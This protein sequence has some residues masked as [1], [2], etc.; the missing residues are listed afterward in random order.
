M[1]MMCNINVSP[2]QI[3][4]QSKVCGKCMT[5]TKTNLDSLSLHSLELTFR[6]KR[7]MLPL[8][9]ND[10]YHGTNYCI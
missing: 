3:F 4:I 6:D 8:N 7:N 9:I 1:F 5:F 2:V 10:F